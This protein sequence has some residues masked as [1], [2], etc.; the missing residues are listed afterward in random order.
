V[1]SVDEKSQIQALDR[2][3][4]GLPMKAGRPATRTHDY[5][6]SGTTTL[7]AALNVLDGTVIGATCS[8]TA[9]RSSSGSAVVPAGKVDHAILD[10]DGAAPA[11]PALGVPLHPDLVLLAA[12]WARMT[13]HD[14]DRRWLL[15]RGHS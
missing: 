6:R 14:R 12:V 5:V 9:T 2:T 10:N 13:P 15:D 4:A 3:Q 7:F 8:V 1:L 11:P